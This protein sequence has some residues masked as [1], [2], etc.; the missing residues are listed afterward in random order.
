MPLTKTERK[1]LQ[2]LNRRAVKLEKEARKLAH[3]TGKEL[4]RQM[5]KS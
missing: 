2:S 5:K 4:V 3:D 1:K